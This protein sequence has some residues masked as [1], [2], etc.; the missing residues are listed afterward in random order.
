MMACPWCDDGDGDRGE[1]VCACHCARPGGCLAY[2]LEDG[3]KFDSRGDG[4]WIT[5]GGRAGQDGKR[6]GGSPVFV[7]NG[8][9]EKGH[10]SL[11]GKSIS[12]IKG[13]AEPS[14][15]RKELAQSRDD[16]T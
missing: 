15:H 11:V 4:R 7:R 16:A 1:C 10:P 8:R 13:E 12:N 2:F 9:I 3:T 14:T 5:I 6:H